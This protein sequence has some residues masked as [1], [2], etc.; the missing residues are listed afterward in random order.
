MLWRH[1]RKK[2]G[3]ATSDDRFVAI[4][5]ADCHWRDEVA[6]VK[7]TVGGQC[8]ADLQ[9]RRYQR[10]G[11]PLS[12]FRRHR[13]EIL[14]VYIICHIV[15]EAT[16]RMHDHSEVK[17]PEHHGCASYRREGNLR[18]L[19]KKVRV[20]TRSNFVQA[21]W[22]DNPRKATQQGC[23][24]RDEPEY[25]RRIWS[26][27]LRSL[28]FAQ[29][30]VEAYIALAEETGVAAQDCHAI[31]ALL[32][33]LRKPGDALAWVERGIDLDKKTPRGSMAGHN[34]AKLK[35]ELLTKLGRGKEALDASWADFCELPSKYTYDDLMKFV[36]KTERT[37]WHLKAIEAAKRA[38]LHSLDRSC[39]W[40]PKETGSARRPRAPDQGSGTGK[41]EPLHHRTRRQETR[42]GPPRPRGPSVAR[43]GDADCQRQE[44]QVLRSRAFRT[45]RAPSA[46]S[47]ARGWP[48]SG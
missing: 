17:V 45:S 33:P 30:D 9:R 39:C 46:I 1:V 2:A 3:L 5:P 28:Y 15:G 38:D 16:A 35:R 24:F 32:I 8:D 20:V 36:P 14:P 18:I 26:E 31:A 21:G 6:P 37:R 34:L 7:L 4:A 29:K 41:F 43:T 22:S 10:I 47:N 27:A 44:E 23:S 40:K 12:S 25:I 42:Q 11:G 48:P 19:A 13:N